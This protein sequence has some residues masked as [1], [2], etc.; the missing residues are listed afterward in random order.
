MEN[1]PMKLMIKAKP[2][3][4][5]FTDFILRFYS[6][7]FEASKQLVS[8]TDLTMPHEWFPEARKMERK[9][10]YHMGPT[11]S[12]KTK[13]AISKLIE[14]RNGIYCSP[15]RLLAWEISETL[16]NFGV[17]CNLIT[18]QEKQL[19]HDATHLAC[20][21]EMADLNSQYDCAVIDEIQLIEDPERGYA[22]TNALLGLQAKEIHICGD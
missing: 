22:W 17:P 8:I 7:E 12:G 3:V 4:E 5:L 11:N 10:F 19:H 14:S 1:F 2:Y 18:G 15:L 13:E 6:E 9:V 16:S 20:T 21:I